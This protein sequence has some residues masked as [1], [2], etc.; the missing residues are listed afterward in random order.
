MAFSLQASKLDLDLRVPT[1]GLKG[2]QDLPKEVKMHPS[3]KLDA[4]L[5]LSQAEYILIGSP[6]KPPALQC[7]LSKLALIIHDLKN[8]PTGEW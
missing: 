8:M 2:R 5:K 7:L 1:N 3:S 6:D 4:L